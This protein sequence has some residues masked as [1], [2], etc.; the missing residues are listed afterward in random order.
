MRVLVTGAGG[1]VGRSTVEALCAAGHQVTA[2]YL[3]GRFYDRPDTGADANV[4][5]DLTDAGAAFAVTREQDAVV[6]AAA[7][8]APTRDPA[9]TV[10]H[11]NLM[12]TFN[13]L[14]AAV[15]W[16][17]RRFVNIS[18]LAVLGWFYGERPVT[19]EYLP[20][21]EEHPVRPHDPY[22]LGK[23]FGE[24]L[25]TAATRRSDIRCISVRPGWV[26]T[27][28]D[29]ERNIR[30]QIRAAEP[31]PVHWTYVDV[32]DVAEAI[33]LAVESD[34]PGHEVLN[35]AAPDS[36]GGRDLADA[37]R[38]RFGDSVAIRELERS[39]SSAI[40]IAKARRL[41]GWEPT[42]SWRDHLDESGSTLMPA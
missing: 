2:T 12:A 4:R 32:H 3:D 17:A 33:R 22:G 24:Q 15:R 37:V 26:H 18:S 1:K 27:A 42:R 31:N 11:N 35:V 41:L 9:A 10:F 20:V 40:D 23:Y 16:G 30:N 36:P 5:A 19:P 21:D 28:R 29:Y 13:T 7:I 39:D 14:E 34:L 6:H 8:P 25:M 38:A